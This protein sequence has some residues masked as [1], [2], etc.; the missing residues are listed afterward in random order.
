MILNLVMSIINR[1]QMEETVQLFEKHNVPTMNVIMCR[2]T[3]TS[4]H[5]SLYGLVP[6]EKAILMTIADHSTTEHLIRAVR[7]TLFIDIP[8]NGIML[9]V[10]IK[11]IGG[12]RTMAFLTSN[13]TPDT[14][15]PTMQFD[16]EL[17]YVILDEGYSDMVMAAARPAGATGG[18]VISSRG[19]GTHH[20]AEKFLG[21]SLANERDVLLIVVDSD[22][23]DAVMRAIMEKAGL[24]TPAKAICFSVPVSRV[25]GL[26]S[27]DTDD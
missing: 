3:A 15:K 25:A 27:H 19:T 1:K 22:K 12:G 6:T 20:Q 11:S 18:T 24:Q 7:R 8:G 23:K 4:E 17:I 9:S 2:G 10:P 5:L 21:I 14:E 26:H 16:H 13:K